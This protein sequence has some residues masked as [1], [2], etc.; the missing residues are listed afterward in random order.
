M[1][2]F[3]MMLLRLSVRMRRLFCGLA[4]LKDAHAG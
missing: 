3:V 2:M 1:S 4:I